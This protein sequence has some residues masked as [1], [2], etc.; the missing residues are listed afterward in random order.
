MSNGLEHEQTRPDVRVAIVGGGCAGMAAAWQL[1]KLGGYKVTVYES[2][3]HLGGKCASSRDSQGRIHEH[4]LHVWLGFYENAF[5]MMR[6]CY[7]EV[8]GRGWGPGALPGDKLSHGSIE[9][10]FFSEP[11][12]GVAIPRKELGDGGQ[13]QWTIWN[14]YL[15]PGQGLPGE[16][17]GDRTGP[18]TVVG[19]LLRCFELLKTLMYSSI[20]APGE[21]DLS[22]LSARDAVRLRE[23]IALG[24]DF[25]PGSLIDWTLRMVKVGALTL[26]S[27][28]SHAVALLEI[29]LKE[30]RDGKSRSEFL[31][32]LMIAVAE[33]VR[34]RLDAV[35][36]IDDTV[37]RKTEIID[38]VIAIAIGVYR[39]RLILDRHGF[40]AINH[41]DYRE[42]LLSHGAARSAVNSQ[43]INGIY[44]FTF[45]FLGGNRGKP[46]LAAG[47]ALRGAFRMFFTYRGAMFWRMR[48]GMGD[49]VF[50]PLYKV[51]RTR[52]V[53]FRF[54]HSLENVGFDFSEDKGKVVRLYFKS[55]RDPDGLANVERAG[56]DSFGCWPEAAGDGTESQL[57]TL[58]LNAGEDFDAVILAIG[59][60]DFVKVVERSGFFDR[61]PKSWS[62]MRDNVKTV[63]TQSVQVWLSRSLLELGWRRGSG[64][65]TGFD[66][67]FDTWA[68]MTHTLA[69]EQEW[70]ASLSISGDIGAEPKSVAYFCGALEDFSDESEAFRKVAENVKKLFSCGVKPVW[71]AAFEN[72]MTA[73]DCMVGEP[74]VQA[75]TVA[76]ARYTISPPGS[77]QF[78]ISPLDQS[79]VNL[80]VA[81][82]W[83][84]CGLDFGCVEAAVISGMLASHAITGQEPAL[85]S[86]VGYDHP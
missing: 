7:A 78:R 23:A 66:A 14:D 82:D 17:F 83:T 53:N 50:A 10:A 2:S 44:D 34:G 80:T 18:F 21:P 55:S 22:A 3:S 26:S 60:D 45:A 49:A 43:F 56:L 20:G 81:G 4:G 25:D 32:D 54:R 1:S 27:V 37:R 62:R 72:E 13:R 8:E 58:V 52:N 76:S 40:D 6:E 74:Y 84:A 28:L 36:A 29:L 61:M 16:D 19:Y 39:D 33:G 5:R 86:I 47:V 65:V 30:F 51:L 48:S 11:N 71:P 67:P 57:E 12:I 68:D 73:Y 42:W 79:L 38:I 35:A 70:R 46:A 15:P 41:L 9:D 59:V 75:N 31:L 64:I 63:S 85:S 77:P 24:G 69:T